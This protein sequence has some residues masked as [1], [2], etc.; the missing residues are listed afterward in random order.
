MVFEALVF[1]V[2]WWVRTEVFS[3]RN[4]NVELEEIFFTS[5]YCGVKGIFAPEGILALAKEFRGHISTLLLK[6][7]TDW[8]APRR[9]FSFYYPSLSQRPRVVLAPLWL[10]KKQVKDTSDVAKS[11]MFV[12][13]ICYSPMI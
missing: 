3:D 11:H 12:F 7:I 2:E 4:R 8:H 6:K 5:S 10:G 1:V 9:G 13:M